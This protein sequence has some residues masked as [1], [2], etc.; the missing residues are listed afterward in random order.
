[1]P[2]FIPVAASS[3][4]TEA[5]PLTR[6]V[7]GCEIA[8]FRNGDSII[9]WEGRCPHRGASLGEGTVEEGVV[10]CPLHGWRFDL[11]TGNCLDRPDKSARSLPVR[12]VDGQI[13]VLLGD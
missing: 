8:L 7:G 2:Q 4:L 12:L 9:A 13:E 6:K 5:R 11:Q 1:M 3:E 10:F